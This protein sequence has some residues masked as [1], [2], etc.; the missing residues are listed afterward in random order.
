MLFRSGLVRVMP[1][2]GRSRRLD[3][4]NGLPDSRAYSVLA[5]R[6][7]VI[8]GTGRGLAR[9]SNDLM[10]ERL[11]PDF[12]DAVYAIE[13]SADTLWLGTS[14]GLLTLLPDHSTPGRLPELAASPAMQAPVL[15][16]AWLADT[17]VAMTDDGLLWRAP[18]SNE[19]TLGPS[20]SSVLG[21]LR[22]FISWEDGF[23]VAGDRGFGYAGLRTAVRRPILGGDLPGVPRGLAVDEQYLCYMEIGRASC[24]ERV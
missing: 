4:G 18:N 13:R 9:V 6:G 7:E 14:R 21:K 1:R 24:R 15:D 10:I 8:V 12:S 23:F 17:L 19:W 16:I 3:M 22:T 20:L 11:A 2:D 5:R